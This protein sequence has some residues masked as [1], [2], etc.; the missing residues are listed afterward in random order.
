LLGCATLADQTGETGNKYKIS[1][2]RPLEEARSN[3]KIPN[4]AFGKSTVEMQT[5]LIR[6]RLF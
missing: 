2:K 3:E 5:G 1:K 6:L 4:Q